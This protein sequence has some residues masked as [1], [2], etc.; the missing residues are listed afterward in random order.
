LTVIPHEC[1]LLG[2]T[3]V[4][5]EGS[6]LG[7]GSYPVG[8]VADGVRVPGVAD[9]ELTADTSSAVIPD[10]PN[11]DSYEVWMKAPDGEVV[12]SHV[13]E[14]PICDLPTLDEPVAAAPTETAGVSSGSL[15]STGQPVFSAAIVAAIAALQAGALIVGIALLRG[16]GRGEHRA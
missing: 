1:D 6:S 9:L 15:A 13:V 5:V 12:D 7:A 16:R 8:V 4:R 3:D 2:A 10:L 11:G 14:L